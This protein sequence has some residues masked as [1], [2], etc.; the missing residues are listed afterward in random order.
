MSMDKGVQQV[1]STKDFNYLADNKSFVG[2]VLKNR[3]SNQCKRI[4]LHS[5]KT[6]R[7]LQF[8]RYFLTKE[9]MWYRNIK[10]GLTIEIVF[11]NKI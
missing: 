2:S 10:E 3:I 7:I 4:L 9:S 11:D 8:D 1:R 6:S 5:E